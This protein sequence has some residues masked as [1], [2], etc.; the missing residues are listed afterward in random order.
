MSYDAFVSFSEK[1]Q[2]EK[3]C[4]TGEV[5]TSKIECDDVGEIIV[6]DMPA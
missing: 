5:F 6:A 4:T 1:G 3:R 2:G